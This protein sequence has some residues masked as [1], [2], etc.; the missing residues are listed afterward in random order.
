MLSHAISYGKQLTVCMMSFC[1]VCCHCKHRYQF[2]S[3]I[4]APCRFIINI[5][6][7]VVNKGL[8]T[9]ASF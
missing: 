4:S 6:D 3:A 7:A 9:I 1:L 5:S 8:E 2:V